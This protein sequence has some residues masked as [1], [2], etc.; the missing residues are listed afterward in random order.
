[1]LNFIRKYL[2]WRNWAI[3]TYNSIF[4]NLFV[5]FYIAL[6]TEN[7]DYNFI[8]DIV[9]FLLFSIFSTTYGYLINDFADIDL[10]KEHGKSN[11]FSEDSKLKAISITTLFFGIS[12]LS[13]YFFIE[14]YA[15]LPLWISWILIS[16]FYS[17]PPIRLK[18]KGKTGLIFVVF[19]Q[20]LIPILLVFSAFNFS[21]SWE[22]IVLA[23]YVFFRGASSDI[24]H[25]LEDFENDIVTGTSTFAVK[26]GQKKVIS[27]LRFSLEVEKVLL[28]VILIY[29]IFM[30][31]DFHYVPFII[32]GASVFLYTV[33][34]WIS[35]Y[36][37]V[38][39]PTIDVNPFKP[40]GS[41]IFQFLHHSF[42]SVILAATLNLI[43][44][45]FNWQFLLILLAF[46]FLKGV[47]SP[48]MIKNSFLF[49]ALFK[50]DNPE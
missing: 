20:R 8:I 31:T 6:R 28:Q 11:T 3:L 46:G 25:Q 48:T 38:R 43:L 2:G 9:I 45:F 34:Y 24:N 21:I 5:V 1:V 16:T 39:M 19:A 4:E 12:V 49:R 10:D 44:V 50:G 26:L 23:I 27:I 30:F 29:F 17:L 35:M 41:G 47:F 33:M 37:I 14:N 32:L 22:I 40:S 15:F 18:E 13:G 36:Q 7:Y 42:P